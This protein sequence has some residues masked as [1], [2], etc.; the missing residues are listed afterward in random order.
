[1]TGTAIWGNEETSSEEERK[2]KMEWVLVDVY[3]SELSGLKN[4]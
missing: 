4:K 1:L 2:G 3:V